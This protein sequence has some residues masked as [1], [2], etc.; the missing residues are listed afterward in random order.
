MSIDSLCLYVY[1][2]FCMPVC[3]STIL[4]VD[5]S[6]YSSLSLFVYLFLS[7]PV[8]PLIPLSVCMAIESFHCLCLPIPLFIIPFLFLSPFPK[9]L[10]AFNSAP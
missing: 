6:I 4:T 10:K 2:L 8:C 5:V 1:R 7:L 9:I 3:I